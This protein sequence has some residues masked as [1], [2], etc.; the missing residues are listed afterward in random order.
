MENKEDKVVVKLKKQPLKSEREEIKKKRIKIILNLLICVFLICAGL[1]I[2]L[3][4]SKPKTEEINTTKLEELKYYLENVWLYND[5]YED[6]DTTLDDKAYYGMT[7]FEDD[8]YTTYMSKEEVSEYASSINMD[9]VGIGVQYNASTFAIT[10]V[11]KESPADNG[12]LLAGDI[13]YSVDGTE[14]SG[15]TS[16]ELKQMVLGEQGTT[17][18]ISVNRGGELLDFTIVRAQVDSSVYAYTNDDYVILEIVSFGENTGNECI[19]Y[20]DEYKDYSKIIIDLRDN[21]GGYETAVQEIAGLFLGKDKVVMHKID[22]SGNTNTDYTISN[23]YYDNFEKIIILTNGNTASASEVLT[24]ALKE[25]HDNV[26]IVGEKTYGKGVVQTQ[27]TLSDGSR[28]KVTSSY[29]TSPNNT[30]INGEGISPDKEVKLDDLFYEVIY[31]FTNEDDT[32][33][34]DSVSNY[35]RIAQLE[36][37]YLGYSVDRS[38]GYFD[39]STLNALNKFKSDNNLSVDGVLD[40]DTYEALYSKAISLYSNDESKD[41]QMNKA[42]ELINE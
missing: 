7:S 24:L 16:D 15:K 20:L 31:K 34:F 9:Y 27:Y 3:L 30:S 22:T 14:V 36:L 29:W 13:I 19:K 12:G 5:E 41:V 1:V 26:T 11:F 35:V 18:D 32:Y 33:T 37:N 2:G 42:K 17:V 6:L 39:T 28:L 4:L 38:D 10:R 21:G 23:A 8:P 25:G 40:N